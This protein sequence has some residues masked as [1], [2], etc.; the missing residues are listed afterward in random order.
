[1]LNSVSLA[2]Q[3]PLPNLPRSVERRRVQLSVKRAFDSIAAAL[4]LLMLAPLL[5]ITALAIVV[6][7]PGPVFFRQA[8]EGYRGQRF[9]MWKFRS[10]RVVHDSGIVAEQRTA[11][12]EG[13][14][15]KLQ[16]D[17]RVTAVGRFIR[18]TSIDELPQL[19]NVLKGDMSLVGPRPLVPF[20]LEPYPE[21]REVRALM[22]PGIT[23]LWQIRDRENNTSALSM[24]PHDLEYISTF[25][26]ALD[27]AI[28]IR[29]V[30]AVVSRKGA[31]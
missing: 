22:R 20:M 6:S 18:A 4:A 9:V 17:P 31:C 11:A 7:A 19:F 28:L 24:M 10:M 2:E 27:A 16:K 30:R 8:R 12:A 5:A 1:M 23:G 21:F 26:L 25:R 29:T 14:L 13:R 15:I 3:L